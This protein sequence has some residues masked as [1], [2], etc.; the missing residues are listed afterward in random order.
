MAGKA[1]CSCRSIAPITLYFFP[2]H[3]VEPTHPSAGVWLE[4]G[5]G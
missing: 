4:S 1:G 2:G 5:L 3:L